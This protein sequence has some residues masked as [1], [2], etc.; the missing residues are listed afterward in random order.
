MAKIGTWRIITNLQ[1]L[2]DWEHENHT[3]HC[4]AFISMTFTLN[5]PAIDNVKLEVI[6]RRRNSLNS[7]KNA[8]RAPANTR[9]RFLRT[10]CTSVYRKKFSVVARL[11]PGLKD[12]VE[13]NFVSSVQGFAKSAHIFYKHMNRKWIHPEILWESNMF[14]TNLNNLLWFCYLLHTLWT[15]VCW[16]LKNL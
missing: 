9:P 12:I 16:N 10:T 6:E 1:Y 14:Y 15:E 11:I 2:S 13:A 7:R 5:I 4:A 3:K 8:S